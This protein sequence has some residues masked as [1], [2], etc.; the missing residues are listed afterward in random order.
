MDLLAS[1]NPMETG[2]KSFEKVYKTVW[3]NN[4]D[5]ISLGYAGT[6]ALKVDFTKTGKRTMKGRFND[7]MNSV[8]RYYLNNFTDGVKQ[9]SID[10]LLG[11]YR[12]DQTSPSPFAPRPGQ[13]S[14]A[15]NL[16][17]AFVF[18]M[19]VFSTLLLFSPRLT[20]SSKANLGSVNAHTLTSSLYTSIGA[21]FV[22]V[23]FIVHKVMKKGS[24]IGERMVVHPTLVPEP[25]R[26]L[27][28]KKAKKA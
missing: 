12:P 14:L 6:G 2:F 18:T 27:P 4:A 1:D 15:D 28:S 13:E 7:G 11:Y 23:L 8:M 26:L 3:A 9:D 10:L 5:A 16:I 19:M 17:K 22:V 24:R 25:I 20:G 21:T